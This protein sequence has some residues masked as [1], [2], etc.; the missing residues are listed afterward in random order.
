MRKEYRMIIV[1][2][3]I[4]AFAGSILAYTYVSTQEAIQRNLD[5]SKKT[6]LLSV[7]KG[8][9][10]YEE[11]VI[12]DKTSILT[13]KGSDGSVLGYGVM[14]TGGGFQGAIKLM[15]G[16]NPSGDTVLGIEVLEN[17]ETPGLGNRIVE[18]GFKKQFEG[19]TPPIEVLKGQ[20]PEKKSQVQAITGATISSKSVAAIVNNAQKVLKEN[21]S[22]ETGKDSLEVKVEGYLQKVM[23]GVRMEK[24][25]SLYF[26]EKEGEILGY[27]II[28]RGLGYSDSVAVFLCV[29]T[30][31][32]RIEDLL[33]LDG[34]EVAV[35]RTKFEEFSQKLKGKALPLNIKGVE[36]VTGA[37]VTQDAIIS[38]VNTGFE[39]LRKEIKNGT[40]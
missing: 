1:L 25:G 23:P 32:S 9:E 18:D 14:I 8:T 29:D 28:A 27:G 36:V 31:V 20:K 2:T 37:T 10:S 22:G 17:V 33:V 26:L 6:A 38:A 15:V 13:A 16:F 40:K 34:S 30:K 5:N 11:Q 12:D 21:L 19:T 7:V 35:N 39:I 4:I 3:V 24:R